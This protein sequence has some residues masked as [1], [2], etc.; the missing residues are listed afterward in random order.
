M[1]SNNIMNILDTFTQDKIY[2][3]AYKSMFNEVL[4]EM[5]W[6]WRFYNTIAT[7]K[8]FS[9]MHRYVYNKHIPLIYRYQLRIKMSFFITRS[10][11]SMRN[12][13]LSA[14]GFVI[15]S[16]NFC[17]CDKCNELEYYNFE[18]YGNNKEVIKQINY[19]SSLVKNKNVRRFFNITKPHLTNEII[20]K[21]SKKQKRYN[22]KISVH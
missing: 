2:K 19:I 7:K 6:K 17:N 10:L 4:E 16:E 11:I 3:I 1:T 22:K 14:K 5:K 8:S 12:G 21:G 18:P 20:C 9:G 15:V 13:W